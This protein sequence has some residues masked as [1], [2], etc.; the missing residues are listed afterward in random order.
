MSATSPAAA[1]EAPAQVDTA[2][3]KQVMSSFCTGVAVVTATA[4]DGAP[5]GMAVQSFASLSLEPPLV[6]F[7]PALTSRSWPRI[8]EAGRFAVSI[9]AEDQSELSRSFAVSG[10]DKFAGVSWHTRANGAPALDGALA[11]IEC[12]LDSELPGGDH[13]IAVARVTGLQ[14]HREA[15]P[16]LYFR[17][18]YGGYASDG[19]PGA[20]GAHAA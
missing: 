8:R 10:G 4:C 20:P 12:A 2:L 7:A 5:V 18:T 1:S 13:T 19:A 3:M 17:R 16:L 9:L 15:G 6:C 14:H 11:T